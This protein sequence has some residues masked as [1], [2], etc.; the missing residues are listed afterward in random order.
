MAE[1]LERQLFGTAVC[2]MT[3]FY[4]ELPRVPRAAWPT[5]LH[6]MGYN[7]EFYDALFVLLVANVQLCLDEGDYTSRYRAMQHALLPFCSEFGIELGRELQHTHRQL[8]AE[9]YEIAT[10]GKQPERYGSHAGNPWLATSRKWAGEMRRAAA[11]ERGGA[12]E[13]ARY[14]LGYFWAVERLSVDEFALMRDAWNA[15]GVRAPYLDTHC[16]VEDDHE[17]QSTRAVLAFGAADD[18]VVAEAIRAH[19]QHLAGYYEELTGLVAAH[20]R[21]AHT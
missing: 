2:A 13:R 6:G 8:Y 14:S 21:A 3:R 1:A 16:S 19:E 10:G 5:L 18:P 4:A 17:A 12:L 15:A 11:A 7:F 20:G 9:F